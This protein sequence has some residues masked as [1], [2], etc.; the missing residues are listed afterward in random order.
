MKA[1]HRL[2]IAGFALGLLLSGASARAAD[3]KKD[4]PTG[5]WT[6]TFMTATGDVKV[7]AKFKKEGDK[8]TGSVTARD[9]ESKIEKGEV[10]DGEFSFQV[11]REIEG[12]KIVF[13]YK[14]KLKG[15]AIDGKA[16]GEF[17]GQAISLDWNAKRDKDSK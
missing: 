7:T 11:T 6:W 10:K 8:V 17:G 4:D 9:R 15:D 16:E 2:A 1:C 5:N 14:G 13:K 3:D 12:E